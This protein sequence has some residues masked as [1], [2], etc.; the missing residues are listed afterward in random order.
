MQKLL[1]LLLIS[2]IGVLVFLGTRWWYQ[3]D[4]QPKEEVS[5]T[6]LLERVRPVLKLITVEGEFSELY[7]HKDSWTYHRAVAGFSP[8]QKRALLKVK[9]RV[10]VG[11]DLNGF[12]LSTD[13]ATRTIKLH[14]SPDPQI[15]SV[16]HDVDFYDIQEGMFNE[17]SGSELTAITTKAKKKV[18]EKVPQSGLFSEAERQRDQ[19][20]AMIDGIAT[21]AGWKF[22][23]D[24]DRG[25]RLRAELHKTSA[26]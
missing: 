4:E 3:P 13:E 22:E 1:S 19:L 17:F 11:Y 10:S 6:V 2:A 25:S 24:P 15:L 14:A 5:A 26:M 23:F 7:D 21:S 20:V 8:F 9:A 16:E 12:R 18:L